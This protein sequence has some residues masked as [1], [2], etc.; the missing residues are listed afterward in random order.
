MNILIGKT[1]LG[2]KV[3]ICKEC[4]CYHVPHFNYEDDKNQKSYSFEFLKAQPLDHGKLLDLEQRYDLEKFFAE[5]NKKNN[6]SNWELA[7]K[8]WNDNNT[9][10]IPD[11]LHKPYYINMIEEIDDF[12]VT[13]RSD[14]L[15]LLERRKNLL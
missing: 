7:V 1:K 9:V 11:N 6:M 8:T 5:I 10:K 13:S 4:E 2:V 14:N 3:S 15:G 12:P